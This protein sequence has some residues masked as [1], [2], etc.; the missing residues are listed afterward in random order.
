MGRWLTA[1]R[2]AEKLSKPVQGGTDKTDKTGRGMVLSVSSVRQEGSS[3]EFFPIHRC[4]CGAVGIVGV[5]WFLRK[6]I[7]A[8]W[9]CAPCFKRLPPDGRA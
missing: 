1:A 3:E 6:P 7:G 8:R 4:G 9:Y 2:E 5:G